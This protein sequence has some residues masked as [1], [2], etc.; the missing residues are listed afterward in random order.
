M[1]SQSVILLVIPG[2]GF[3]HKKQQPG[4]L[5]GLS[6]FCA[7][8]VQQLCPLTQETIIQGLSLLCR[9][10]NGLGHAFVKLDLKEK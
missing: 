4:L 6:S 10:G 2:S 9:T 8:H 5:F 1:L 3:P 7:T